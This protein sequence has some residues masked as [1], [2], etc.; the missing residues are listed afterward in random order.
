MSVLS[1]VL[2]EAPVDFGLVTT[3]ILVKDLRECAKLFTNE[4]VRYLVDMYY[5]IQKFRI[6]SMNQ[7][8]ALRDSGEPNRF[9]TWLGEQMQY[10]EDKIK[11]ALDVY[12]STRKLGVWC[13]SITGI[14]PVITA[15]LM[16]HI[17]ITKAPT[18]GHIWSFA[19]LN[20]E[21]VW[22]KG[23]VR[24]WNARL[25]TLCWKVGESFVKVKNRPSDIY[26]KVYEAR[27]ALETERNQRGEYADKAAAILRQK[28]FGKDTEAYKWYS[29]GMLPPGHIHARAKRYAV[30]LFLAHYHHVAYLLHYGKEPPKPYVITHLGHADFVEPPNLH[31]IM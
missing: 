12:T 1:E 28:N 13:K 6:N 17:D 21:A 24:P 18:V 16:A 9:V 10:L 19:G 30:K 2:S 5:S 8:R 4:E 22:K 20:P 7:A 14:G 25:K 31:L 27:K 11:T 3:K 15:G 29:Q 23:Q 26:G